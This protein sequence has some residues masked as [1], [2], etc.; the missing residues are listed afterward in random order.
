[1]IKTVNF[2]I[3]LSCGLSGSKINDDLTV[4]PNPFKNEFLFA[5][6]FNKAG[7][8]SLRF[9]DSKGAVVKREQNSGKRI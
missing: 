2:Q 7:K 3:H 6:G 1:M 5:A 4:S 8:I 9:T